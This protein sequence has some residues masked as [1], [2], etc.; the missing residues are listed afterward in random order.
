MQT[1]KSSIL[2]LGD[3]LSFDI[4]SLDSAADRVVMV[5]SVRACEAGRWH[6]RRLAF[7]IS[8]M[9]HF[10]DALR[11]KGYDVDYYEWAPDFASALKEHVRRHH[12]RELVVMKPKSQGS[13]DL[14]GRL[15]KALGISVRVTGNNQ[16]MCSDAEFSMWLRGRKLPTIQHFYRMMRKTRGVL[17][18][19][20]APAGGKWTYEKENKL[21]SPQVSR[22]PELPVVSD[23]A[24]TRTVVKEVRG[25]FPDHFGDLARL[26]LPV[27][28]KAALKWEEDFV[29]KRLSDYG[30]F[31]FVMRSGS[32]VLFHSVTSP[33]LNAGL[34]SPRECVS[35]A[36]AAYRDGLV[37]ISS[38]EGYVRQV[39]GWR[40][41]VAGMY[42]ATADRI[43]SYNY[44]GSHRKLPAFF[45]DA[46]KARMNCVEHAIGALLET[47]YCNHSMRLMVI[48]NFALLAG[49][50]PVELYR[51]FLS[52]S[53]DACEWATATD[54][55]CLSQFGDGGKV[56]R[57][58]YVSTAGFIN[59]Y[60]DYCQ[61]CYYSWRKKTGENACPFNYLYWT[62]LGKRKTYE[63]KSC[64][65]TIPHRL[66]AK[67]SPETRAAYEEQAR[68]FLR[69]P[70]M[71]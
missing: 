7:V 21:P 27:D 63:V 57:K 18:D 38:A 23:D 26:A 16:F 35:I 66:L 8:A 43:M 14:V 46:S 50:D 67:A 2:I 34:L 45:M 33:L 17:M 71:E 4:S 11:K 6:K 12:V 31:E 9:R 39:L 29:A 58:P 52:T 44:F 54:V 60:S 15:G 37:P 24:A 68:A 36:E 51:W 25:R 53:V 59:T 55:I 5:E 1:G 64:R 32:P 41:Y 48:G 19:D 47:G 3:Q 70:E 30:S 13:I 56:A 62:F 65:L 61:S 28:R 10:R 49:L 40:E 69:S 20:S 42:T 22:F